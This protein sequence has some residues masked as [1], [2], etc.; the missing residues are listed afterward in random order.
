MADG[1]ITFSTKLDNKALEK[2]LD[3]LKKEIQKTEEAISSQEA[4]KSPMVKQAAEL[5]QK[6]KAARAEVQRCG[7]EWAA[8]VVGADTQQ[9]KAQER[10]NQIENEYNGIVQQ[11]DKID[12]KLIPAHEKLD[13]M[14]EE[15]GGLE[16]QL[17]EAAKNTK[18]ME[19]ATKKAEKHMGTFAKRL[20][21]I[22]LSA[23]VFN[24]LSSGFR[25]V[26]EWMGKIIKNNDKAR[27]SLAKLKAALLTL[28]QPLV[29]VIIPVFADIVN[30]LARIATYAAQFVAILFGTTAKEASKSAEE[31]YNEQQA[32]EGVGNA[33]KKAAKQLAPFDEINRLTGETAASVT[34][35]IAP[36]FT[37][38]NF[39][40]VPNWLKN[41]AFDL[42]AKITGLK[43][44]WDKGDFFKSQDGWII[45]LTGILGAVLGTMFGGLSG[46]IIGLLLGLS[47]GLIS[48]TFLDK[49]DDPEVVKDSVIIALGAILG[50]ALGLKFGGITG[51]IIGLLLG[52][53]VT[54][55]GLEFAK[56]DTSAWDEDDT[57]V[58]VLSAILGAILGAAFGGLTGAVI[59]LLLGGVISFVS[60]KFSEGNYNKDEAIAT[61][62]VAIF[63]ILGAVLGAMFGGFLGGVVGLLLGLT[64]G[65]TTVAFDDN[66]NASTRSTAQKALK[67]ALT[68]IIGALVG[69]VFGGGV[70]GGIVGGV[71][72][73]TYG[74]AITLN[75]A[76][77]TNGF[78]ANTRG[79]G[80]SANVTTSSIPGF[81][82]GSV[83]PPNREFLAVLGD[84]KTETEVVSPLSTMKQ[85]MIEALRE[86]GGSGGTYT[87]VVNLDGKEVA[88]NQVK[89]IND[90]TRQAGKP[91][92]L[93]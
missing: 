55:I 79:S 75:D 56:G 57:L 67:V 68:T 19:K 82:T 45:A 44:K 15:A 51:G 6:M 93:F 69:A 39:G 90:M 17:G 49:V 46:T 59:G 31:L 33:A 20:K 12:A 38:L 47:V 92:L 83:I 53:L 22:A 28:A 78:T 64:I 62:R 89:H 21:G 61:L 30:V 11:I 74:L 23:F 85:A 36:D 9:A 66:L 14:K 72:G 54:L 76:K 52:T 73:L 70:F 87:F 18:K 60:I 25:E 65:F 29:D 48:C 24:V 32:I 80:F 86:S 81:A 88:R 34:D 27:A 10:L 71:I 77:I 41:L 40:E 26:T 2:D 58:V 7:Q 5:E 91:V 35:T 4:K 1:S 63:A 8:G 50:L 3:K 37:G 42:E 43:F 16:Q 13:R 84:N